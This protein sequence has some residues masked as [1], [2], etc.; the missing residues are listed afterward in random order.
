MS[1][2]T[3]IA[4]QP[5]LGALAAVILSAIAGCGGPQ[6]SSS[7]TPNA[8]PLRVIV[9]PDPVAFLPRNGEPMML[10][11]EIAQGLAEY[12]GRPYEP[13]VVADYAEMIDA[14]LSGKGDVIAAELSVTRER[15]QL[16]TFSLPYEHVDE[17][18]IVPAGERSANDW[19]DLS[20]KTICVRASSAYAGTLREMQQD[21]LDVRISAQ[22][23]TLN[24][25]EIVDLVDS[26]KCPATLVDSNLWAAIAG[27]F[28]GLQALRPLSENRAIALAVRPDDS[29]LVARINQY[30]TSRALS[31]RHER[32]YSDDLAGLKKRKV[33]RMLTRNSAASYYLYR[34]APYGF[35]YELMSRFAD[36][37]GMRLQVVIPPDNESLVSWLQEGRGDVIAA[38]WTA[39][40]A[41]REQVRFSSPYYYTDE[42]LVARS[43]E[44][45]SGPEQLSGRHVYVR[46]SASYYDSLEELN[47]RTNGFV[48]EAAPEDMQTEQILAKVADGEWD[49]TVADSH[50]LAIEQTHGR[51]LEAAFT[52][53]SRQPIAWAVRKKNAALAEALSSYAQDIYRGT[54]Y[55][56]IR[57]RYFEDKKQIS[58]ANSQWRVDRSGKLS[59][60]DDLI[61]EYAARN[62]FDWRL[63]AAQAFQESKFEPDRKS[64]AG[65]YGLMQV[66]PRVA[67]EVGISDYKTPEG[68]IAAGV[69][70]L[71]QMVDLLDP[72]LPLETRL[73]FGLASYNAGR[74]HLLDARRLAR[75]LG[76]SADIWYGNVEKAMLLLSQSKYHRDSRFGY[77]RGTEPVQYVREIEQ[78]YNEYITQLPQRQ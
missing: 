62:N 13:V 63:I 77:V 37:L 75:K 30:L 41:R 70:Y 2:S 45:I 26:G 47:E 5:G 52:L 54:T 25:E 71:R 78:R 21:D 24:T 14:L 44:D 55:N 27:Y 73:R 39:T 31:G 49:L 35:D 51:P 57:K 4:R 20:G 8:E 58:D 11:R 74:G 18:L 33:L 76:W 19:Q 66:L 67:Q 36:R 17:L 38:M 16:V 28:D 65:A 1:G 32:L 72:K 53:A 56:V 69:R 60:Y 22:P 9:R 29:G 7:G 23:D 3:R 43:D 46:R 34:G 50:L 64:W 61:R 42:V 59:P 10:D 6:S 40:P 15:S 48:I 12:L 68:S